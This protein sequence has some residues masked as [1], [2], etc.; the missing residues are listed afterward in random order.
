MTRRRNSTLHIK[1]AECLLLSTAYK[2]TKEVIG[3]AAK[4]LKV[5]S[6]TGVGVDN[7]DVKAATERGVLVLNTPEANSISV[8]EHTLALIVAISKQLLY[9]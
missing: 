7:V 1:D 4:N 6:R 2:M 9:V 8:A 3:T 5:I